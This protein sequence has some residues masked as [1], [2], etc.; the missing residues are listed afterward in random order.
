MMIFKKL[1]A[2]FA[3]SLIITPIGAATAY[4]QGFDPMM[5]LRVRPP[6]PIVLPNLLPTIRQIDAIEASRARAE[7]DRAETELIRQQTEA[8]RQKS[9]S[10]SAS[11]P[12][13]SAASGAELS[14]AIKKWL[15]VAQPRMHLYPDFESVVFAPD[16]PLTESI[17]SLM[18][19]RSYAADIAY[20]LGKNKLEAYA[21][22]EM[23]ILQA[24]KA[25][26]EIEARLKLKK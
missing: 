8:M 10:F 25:I 12:P 20:Y 5:A 22:S 19:E 2:A 23:P 7:R 11:V 13:P 14:P 15:V 1:G 9:Q 24:D 6:A 26:S 4:G 17:I 21:I 16:V 3:A 18:S